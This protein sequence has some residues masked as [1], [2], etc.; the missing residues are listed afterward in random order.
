M[1]SVLAILLAPAVAAILSLLIRSHTFQR[2]VTLISSVVILIGTLRLYVIVDPDTALTFWD[3][4]L[5][6]DGFGV[7]FLSITALVGFFAT[8]YSLGYIGTEVE[9]GRM[10]ARQAQMY[11]TLYNVFLLS[12]LFAI[13]CNNLGLLWVVIE[14]TTL[15][16]AYLVG[17]YRHRSSVEAAWKYMVISSV[18]LTLA[19]IGTVVLY[20]SAFSLNIEEGSLLLHWDVLRDLAPLL[21][22][23][24]V[25]IA[26]VFLLVGYGT[27]MGLAPMH[28]WLPDAHGHAPTPISGLLSGVLLNVALY[29]FL[30]AKM[31]IDPV[32]GSHFTGTFMLILGFFSLIVASFSLIR[33]DN[34]KRLLAYSSIEH[35]GLI[36]IGFAL[37]TPLAIFA[38][39]FHMINHS[40]AKSF[41]FFSAGQL[42]LRYQSTKISQIRGL[43]KQFPI[44]G[45]TMLLAATMLMGFPPFN[46]FLSKFA[47]L[48]AVSREHMWMLWLMLALLT[49]VLGGFFFNIMRLFKNADTASGEDVRKPFTGHLSHWS[50]SALVLQGAVLLGLGIVLPLWLYRD[51]SAIT[52][53]MSIVMNLS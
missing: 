19:L 21:N 48:W 13:L 23:D 15:A 12:M 46:I 11:Y 5:R 38:A 44:T 36:V 31:I 41:A 45:W 22:P 34:I 26:F 53:W 40:L 6:L 1:Y 2:V 14:A 3:G 10:D 32:L 29:A 28:T 7:I 52:Q 18:G 27:K 24:L 51:L 37:N 33:Q 50:T 39:L 47:L 17:I 9:H 4:V 25:K 49:I 16:S 35:M 20:F 30:R 8:L 43:M 42:V